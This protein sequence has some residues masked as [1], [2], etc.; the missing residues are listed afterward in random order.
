[1][2]FSAVAY[3]FLVRWNWVSGYFLSRPARDMQDSIVHQRN[4]SLSS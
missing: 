1:L 2:F 4:Q 3:L